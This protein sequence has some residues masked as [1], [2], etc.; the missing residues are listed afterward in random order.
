MAVSSEYLKYF[1]ILSKEKVL[2]LSLSLLGEG[3]EYL[4]STEFTVNYDF[5]LLKESPKCLQR[6]MVQFSC[7]QVLEYYA[8]EYLDKKSI[9]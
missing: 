4:F 1:I 3:S 8:T 6:T 2:S 7:F 5:V 9:R